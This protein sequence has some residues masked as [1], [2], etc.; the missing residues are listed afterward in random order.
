[1]K[2]GRKYRS[3]ERTYVTQVRQISDELC[4]KHGLSVIHTEK[5]E[6]VARP[7]VQWLPSRME[8][9]ME[10]AHPAGSQCGC[11]RFPHMEAVP[12]DAGEARLCFRFDRKHPA[13]IL[14]GNG[15]TVRFKT[16]GK[17]YTPEA[18]Q[19]RILYPKPPCRWERTSTSQPLPSPSW[20]NA[21]PQAFRPAGSLL[22]LP[23][24][25]GGAAE[26]APVS[27]LCCAGGYPQAGQ[28]D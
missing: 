19:R 25:D 1:M 6:Q 13:L 21:A 23:V 24:Q 16:L 7:Y 12:A 27:K 8:R 9:H 18:L 26:K 10:N 11:R 15:R 5:S 28:T 14:P 20:G 4:K 2:N 22:F 17:Q 3:N